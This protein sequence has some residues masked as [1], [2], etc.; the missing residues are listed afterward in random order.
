MA[1]GLMLYGKRGSGKGLAAV[2]LIA[3]RLKKGGYV[4]TN[5]NL[6]VEHLLPPHSRARIYR[7][8]DHPSVEDLIAIGAGNPGI[9]I[10]AD[11]EPVMLDSF[12]DEKNGLLVLDEVADYLNARDWQKKGRADLLSWLNHSRKYGWDLIFIGQGPNQLDKQV[13][14]NLI[15]RFGQLRRLDKILVPVLGTFFSWF[16]YKFT[17]PRMHLLV[18]RIGSNPQN[19]VSERKVFNNRHLYSAYDTLQ[20]FHPELGVRQGEGF[21]YLS[22]WHL[23]GRYMHPL[24]LYFPRLFA[25]GFA[26]LVFGFALGFYLPDFFTSSSV[27][28]P[29]A[30][31][32]IPPVSESVSGVF[33]SGSVIRVMLQDGTVFVA[34]TY[35]DNDAGGRDYFY[36]GRWYR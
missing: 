30:A 16:G 19:P 34:E 3:E 36:A 22:P 20:V 2:S 8:P 24:K 31:S 7:V 13:R 25:L 32:A 12:D 9:R 33:R 17:L 14:D 23:K 5:L 6:N 18:V 27:S 28:P 35:R 1:D 11:G 21:C 10:D 4:A 15:D 26:L 29:V